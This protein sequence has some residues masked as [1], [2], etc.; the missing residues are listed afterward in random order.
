M[1]G[2]PLGVARQVID[3]AQSVL[4]EK[5]RKFSGVSYTQAG[6]VQASTVQASTVQASTV[7]ASIA[8]AETILG[9]TQSYAYASLDTQW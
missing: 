8:N 9:G 5:G 1:A 6:T 3:E 4:V 2:V 7:Q